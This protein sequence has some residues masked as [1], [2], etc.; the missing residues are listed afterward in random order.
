MIVQSYLGKKLFRLDRTATCGKTRGGV[1]IFVSEKLAPFTEINLI[2]TASTRDFEILTVNVTKPNLKRLIISCVYKP[3]IGKSDL[4]KESLKKMYTGIS[5]EIWLLGDFN[6][7]YLDRA[8]ENRLKYLIFLK[9]NGMKQIIN[10]STRPNLRGG[11]CIDWIAINTDFVNLS[12]VLDEIDKK[13][14]LGGIL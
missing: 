14:G 10:V 6:V 5:R 12:G 11:T 8:N 3:P 2:C 9:K 13:P 1:C 7:D 4:L